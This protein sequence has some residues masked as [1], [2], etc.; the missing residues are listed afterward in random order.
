[1]LRCR[2]CCGTSE[3]ARAYIDVNPLNYA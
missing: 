1:M 3:D 2:W